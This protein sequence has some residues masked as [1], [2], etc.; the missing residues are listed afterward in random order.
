ML[1]DRTHIRWGVISAGIL[2]VSTG[3]YTVYAIQATPHP[4]A[5]SVVGLL[6]GITASLMMVFAGLLA[7]RTRFPTVRCGSAQFWL[8]GHLWLGALSLV[9][10]FFHCNFRFGST[11]ETMLLIVFIVAI[12]SGVYGVVLQQ[13]LPRMISIRVPLE[14]FHQQVPFLCRRL[15]AESDVIVANMCGK[16][17][18]EHESVS[19]AAYN[20]ADSLG[21]LRNGKEGAD[22]QKFLEA[23]YVHGSAVAVPVVKIEQVETESAPEKGAATT[24]KPPKKQP[25]KPT[26]KKGQADS[27]PSDIVEPASAKAK[28]TAPKSK[29]EMIREAAA[30]KGA[31]PDGPPSEKETTPP[32]APQG[33]AAPQTDDESKPKES[34]K[35]VEKPKVDM[36]RMSV[37]IISVS[38]PKCSKVLIL[39]DRSFLGRFA[40]CP[41]CSQKFVLALADAPKD[42]EPPIKSPSAT[43]PAKHERAE[44]AATASPSPKENEPKLR[45]LARMKAASSEKKGS[46]KPTSVKKAPGRPKGKPLPKKPAAATNEPIP[47]AEILKGFYLAN[48]RPFLAYERNQRRHVRRLVTPKKFAQARNNLPPQLHSVLNQLQSFCDERRQFT[49]H[50]KLH[51]T[52]HSWLLVH[53]PASIALFVLLVVHIVVALRVIP[54][55]R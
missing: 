51:H 4:S 45:P 36:S 12:V 15:Q 33:S 54:W 37:E 31:K 24:G 16:I 39:P 38:C 5:G 41:Q 7:V 11:L 14:T 19:D 47:R 30:K 48:V 50:Q 17:E 26:S 10:G 2:V 18:C 1:I 25:G 22:F 40:N 32:T 29:V 9:L 20:L 43:P 28:P 44:T 27:S 23:T 55:A 42:P 21:K 6:F 8:R 3:I 13:F 49:V 35:E 46:E 34:A 52:L 53:I